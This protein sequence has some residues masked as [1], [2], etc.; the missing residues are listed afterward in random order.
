MAT[1][2]HIESGKRQNRSFCI[3]VLEPHCSEFSQIAAQ[4][5]TNR[6]WTLRSARFTQL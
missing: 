6:S 4:A 1:K 3:I 2:V 5:H